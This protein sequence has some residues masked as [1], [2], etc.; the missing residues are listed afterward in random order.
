M[1]K[2]ELNHKSKIYTNKLSNNNNNNN[3]F[4]P[5]IRNIEKN[6]TNKNLNQLESKKKLKLK[7][8]SNYNNM[9]KE[10]K[11]S[12]NSKYFINNKLIY[13]R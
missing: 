10:E 8:N 13:L 12:S 7:F 4:K 2:E 9:L 3:N 11:E 1:E 5:N 6:I